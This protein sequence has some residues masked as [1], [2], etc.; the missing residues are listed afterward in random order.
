MWRPFQPLQWRSLVC[1]TF[2][3]LGLLWKTPKLQQVLWQ[4]LA[5]RLAQRIAEHVDLQS[6]VD[7]QGDAVME[8]PGDLRDSVLEMVQ[9]TFTSQ[10]Q[11]VVA[12]RG[13]PFVRWDERSV[14]IV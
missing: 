6:A 4:S 14:F 13:A 7:E 10:Y 9:T 11:Q 8:L 5:S 2:G 12:G 3:T 1:N